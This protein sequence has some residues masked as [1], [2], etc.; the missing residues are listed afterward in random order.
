MKPWFRPRAPRRGA[1]H[2]ARAGRSPLYWVL[3]LGLVL[4]GAG[5]AVRASPW[6]RETGLRGKSLPELEEAA[7]RDPQ[8]SLAQ[9]YLA[10]GYYLSAR[11]GDARRAYQSAVELDPTSAR[12]HL[13]LAL[14]L[15]ELGQLGA[16]QAEFERT[17]KL[18]P[19]LAWPEYMLGKI[20]WLRGNTSEALPHVRRATELDPRSDPAW[21]ALSVCYI[22]L[23]RYE[24]GI[25]A[26][27]EALKRA[28]ATPSYHTAIGEVLAY[29]G[30]SDEGRQ[31]YERALQL[32]PDYGP[33]CALMG[34]F[35][36]RKMPGL[37]AMDRARDL[38]ER[39]THLHTYHP[40][41]VYLDLGDLYVQKGE[42]RKAVEALQSS[43]RIDPRDERPY[44]TLAK[45]YRRLGDEPAAAAAEARFRRISRL[46]VDMQ[47]YQARLFHNPGDTASRLALARVYRE[48]GLRG[49]AAEQYDL[50]VRQNP[51]AKDV[52]DE[53][54]R[55]LAETPPAAREPGGSDFSLPPL[56]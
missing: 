25:A 7:R 37:S 34:E 16:A 3:P 44:F 5:W 41:Q 8:D 17:L 51:A 56:R 22:Q 12:A 38:L 29:R 9:Y 35:Y 52:A 4:I 14:S 20:A 53:F 27:R 48:I 39:A 40:E 50:Y 24:E 10:K 28:E 1:T 43:I 2:T 11:F 31:H 13:G 15:F 47:A 55:F 18:S 21:Y 32:N 23:K 26:L 49:D 54:R 36:L 6:A 42:P 45:A 46:H 33:A 30:H 19:R